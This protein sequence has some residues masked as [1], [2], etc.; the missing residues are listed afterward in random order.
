MFENLEELKISNSDADD[1]CF[2][3]LGVCCK[4]LR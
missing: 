4:K 3:T 1:D 2:G